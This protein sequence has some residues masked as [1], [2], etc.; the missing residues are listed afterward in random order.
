MR[1]E[2]EKALEIL[3]QTP[4]VLRLMLSDL[5]DSWTHGGDRDDWS[6]FDI[7]GHLINAELTDWIPRAKVILAQDGSVFEPFDRYAQFENSKGKILAEL[8]DEFEVQRSESLMWLEALDITPEK[9]ALKCT[10]PDLGEVTMSQLFATW[11]VH[12]LTHIRQIN[13]FMAK[14]YSDAVGPWKAYLSILK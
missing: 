3:T 5:S 12:D 14:E 7:V 1:F 9:L 10:H 13:I 2:L 11:V 4:A 6:P 8:L